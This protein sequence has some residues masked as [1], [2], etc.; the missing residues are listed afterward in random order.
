M[1]SDQQL[2]SADFDAT[3]YLQH[4]LQLPT[5]DA[6]QQ[7]LA[8]CVDRVDNELRA[9][10][11]DNAPGLIG[12]VATLNE[13]H[14]T[15]D[16]VQ[17]SISA[18]QSSLTRLRLVIRDPYTHV[19][20][21]VTE[22]RNS[23]AALEMMRAVSRFLSYTAKLRESVDDPARAARLLR[24]IEEV[25][26][27]YDLA[28]IDAVDAELPLVSK[29]SASVRTKALEM[30]RSAMAHRNHA[31]LGL[32][33]QCFASLGNL[34][35]IFAD[36]VTDRKRDTLTVIVRQLS[37]GA[38]QGDDDAALAK[39]DGAL[40]I[41]ADHATSL[42]ELWKALRR[43]DASTQRPFIDIVRETTDPASLLTD[44]WKSVAEHLTDQF[45]KLTKMGALHAMLVA[46]FA[47]FYRH[48]SKFGVNMR[49][50]FTAVHQC[51]NYEGAPASSQL[52]FDQWI[53]NT[54]GDV[55]QRFV[56]A[57]NERQREKL[58][59]FVTRLQASM[60]HGGADSTVV[61]VNADPKNTSNAA[62]STAAANALD[63]PT[64]AL[65]KAI[66]H[67]LAANR[68][69]EHAL[70]LCLKSISGTL[71]QLVAR[72]R[73]ASSKIPLAELPSIAVSVTAGQLFHISLANALTTI[74][75]D[76]QSAIALLPK[77]SEG[78][79]SQTPS[80]ETSSLAVQSTLGEMD[81]LVK[82]VV[83]PF[84]DSATVALQKHVDDLFDPKAHAASSDRTAQL[85][86][87]VWH[88]ATRFSML[89]DRQAHGL[90]AAQKSLCMAVTARVIALTLLEQPSNRK[91]VAKDL[92][93]LAAALAPLHPLER[94]GKLSR[95]HRHLVRL[96]EDD[97]IP[98]SSDVRAL[99]ARGHPVVILL[100]L[101]LRLEPPAVEISTA[102]RMSRPEVVKLLLKPLMEGNVKGC[103]V[104]WQA[105]TRTCLA[106]VD[107]FE[108]RS[109]NPNA[110]TGIAVPVVLT[111]NAR[112]KQ[113][114]LALEEDL[115]PR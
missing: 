91:V 62:A 107:A 85:Q 50:F 41:V 109:T 108:K 38:L 26:N 19:Q 47:H 64:R 95:A 14:V 66:N 10:I 65:L 48:L 42:A 114:C 46:K 84:F 87:R 17:R 82:A 13:A 106:D 2:L 103:A 90:E 96:L 57:M 3:A 9:A 39:L 99:A 70:R 101:L 110:E 25:L 35:K 4:T 11:A 63:A 78:T 75:T 58:T 1:F 76:I 43:K 51:S 5:F 21:A 53:R 72:S 79:Q 7:R 32:A 77:Q 73:E 40:Q 30:L 69:D 67:E 36:T 18:A 23:T 61:D 100:A 68:P 89:F 115:V 54:V 56:H 31:E 113:G 22:L 80:V 104:M 74:T 6:E 97:D 88:F 83:A 105:A 94:L 28:G 102:M 12:S 33:V 59:T 29:A 27:D 92:D 20:S 24:D 60:P 16:D 93:G 81:K 45:H 37:S 44:Y 52:N 8:R 112:V 71:Q 55:E 49:D 15:V 34:G 86:S 111:N 98:D